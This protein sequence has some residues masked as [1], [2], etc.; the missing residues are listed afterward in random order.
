MREETTRPSITLRIECTSVTPEEITRRLGVTPSIVHL[1]GERMSQNN[2]LSVLYP[3]DLWL[4]EFEERE[5]LNEL[6]TEVGNFFFDR[7]TALLSF[8]NECEIDLFCG[9]FPEDSQ[10]SFWID[11]ESIRK[12]G[13][14]PVDII[15]DIYPA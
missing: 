1:K 10:S 8:V 4:F 12:I 13:R 15:F 6:F 5:T 14:I 3:T 9:F 11:R 2:P 7:E